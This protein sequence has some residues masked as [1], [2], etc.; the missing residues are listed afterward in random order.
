MFWKRNNVAFT[1]EE[2]AKSAATLKDKP[3]LK[4]H[5]AKV[6]SIVGRTTN[7]VLFDSVSKN[8][9]FEARIEDKSMINKIQKGLI[10]H[11]SVGAFVNEDST[12]DEE[13]GVETIKGIDF[14]ELSL[15]AIPA[16]PDAGMSGRRIG[17]VHVQRILLES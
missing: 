16:D 17:H 13:T 7:N 14:V 11:V 8:I 12:F 1:G 15:V 5:D 9:K 6:D 2:L 3:I 10:K 4:D